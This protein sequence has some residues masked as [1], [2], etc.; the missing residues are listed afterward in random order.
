MTVI[1]LYLSVA[2]LND[3]IMLDYGDGNES[4]LSRISPDEDVVICDFGLH[5]KTED[6]KKLLEVTKN[7]IWIDHL[8]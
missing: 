4:W 7:V 6:M 5:H 8:G 1:M 3:F 2:Y